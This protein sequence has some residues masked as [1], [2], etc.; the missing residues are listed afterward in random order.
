LRALVRRGAD[1][2]PEQVLQIP[3]RLA[4]LLSERLALLS[5]SVRDMLILVSAS[6]RPTPSSISRALEDPPGFGDDL[7]AAVQADVIEISHDRIEFSNPLLGTALYSGSS[8]DER[9]RAH[10]ML[11]EGAS[12]R[13]EH[14]RHLAL[15]A[16]GPDEDVAQLLEDTAQRARSHGAPDAAAQLAELSMALTPADRVDARNRR[17]A[18]AGRYAFEAAQVERAE[19]LLQEATAASTGPMRAGIRD[20]V[21]RG[22][23]RRESP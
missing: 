7:Q 21:E 12:D 8:P 17:T 6:P 1:L 16:E 14:A 18:N 20:R 15:A 3:E 2:E 19:E 9:R 5:S 4:E 22:D 11:A 13:E 10:R 23:A